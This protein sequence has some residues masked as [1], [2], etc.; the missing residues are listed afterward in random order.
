MSHP[1]TLQSSNRRAVSRPAGRTPRARVAANG[2]LKRHCCP[3]YLPSERRETDRSA[4]AGEDREPVAARVHFRSGEIYGG[5]DRV[6]DYGPLGTELKRNLKDYWWRMMVRAIR[7]GKP[8][9]APSSRRCPLLKCVDLDQANTSSPTNAAYDRS[10]R[11]SGRAED[12]GGLAFGLR[13]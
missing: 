7:D 13:G 3:T 4:A 1:P 12:Q 6:W 5:L 2:L 8:E 11:A 9:A 10:I